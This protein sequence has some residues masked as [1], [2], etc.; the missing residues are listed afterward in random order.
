[1]SSAL[2]AKLLGRNGLRLE[3]WRRTG[4]LTVI[5]ESQHRGI[6]RVQ[7]PDLDLHV[8]QYRRVG[9]RGWLR[10]LIRPNKARREARLA[11]EIRAR[12]IATP[13]PLGWSDGG[14]I[15]RTER[16]VSLLNFIE[17]RPIHSSAIHRFAA[18]LGRFVA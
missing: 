7:L 11:Q 15:T 18:E 12:G 6:Y 4:R 16:G 10:E 14:I 1:M 8:K 9:L 2:R 17:S 3:E 5:K 13:E